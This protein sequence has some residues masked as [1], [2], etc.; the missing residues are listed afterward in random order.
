M[1][2]LTAVRTFIRVADLGSFA[3][4]ARDLGVSTSSVS[5]LVGDLEDHLGVRLLSR[6]TRR[7]GLTEAGDAYREEA[8]GIVDA[9]DQL[10]E[11]AHEH[12]ATPSGKLRVTAT[13][14]LGES[15]VVSLLPS[16]HE[17]YPEVFIELDITDRMVD[18]VSEGFDLGV[19]TGILRDSSMIAKRMMSIDYI[20]CASP[21]YIARCGT[22]ETPDDLDHHAC[23][24]Y[25]QP[26]RE[27][28]LWWFECNGERITRK[29][30][31][32][33]SINNA[34]GIRDMMIAGAGIGFVP[35]FVVRRDI[36]AG[37][38]V[39]LMTGWDASAD[40]V[41]AV[42]PS[43]QHIPAKLR[44]FVDHLAANRHIRPDYQFDGLFTR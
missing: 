36:E 18:L 27:G 42:Y 4:A 9:F 30:R 40:E 35:D 32:I 25:Q 41:H 1:D 13:V 15:W 5:R 3:A 12:A 16:F 17:A 39:R 38:L 33:M 23:I 24:V 37:R 34:W 29:V 31:G 11:R 7:I 43:K 21:A 8:R 44:A 19:R 26:N 28:E 14:A 10:T 2:Q 6:T 22:P 20:L